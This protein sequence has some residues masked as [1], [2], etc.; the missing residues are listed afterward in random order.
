MVVENYFCEEALDKVTLKEVPVFPRTLEDAR[1][2]FV[3]LLKNEINDYLE[4]E[5]YKTYSE[6]ILQKFGRFAEDLEVPAS[7]DLAEIIKRE[8]AG[9]FPD[10]YWY[11][12]APVDLRSVAGEERKNTEVW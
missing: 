1:E 11:L 7:K 3:W 9:K 12:V 10:K 6:R 4:E 5:Q 2:W 8:S